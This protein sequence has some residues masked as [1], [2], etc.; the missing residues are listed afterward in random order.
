MFFVQG[1]TPPAIV[2]KLNAAIRAAIAEPAVA[3]ILQR[4]G[5][6]PDN[7]GAEEVG[8]FFRQEVEKTGELVK[9]AKI[10]AN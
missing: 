4:D 2:E 7:R 3:N 1:K 6:F 9:A 10:E 8:A 5:Y